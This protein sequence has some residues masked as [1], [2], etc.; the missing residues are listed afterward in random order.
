M[1]VFVAGATGAI[2]QVVAPKAF[3]SRPAGQ[4]NELQILCRGEQVQVTLNGQRITDARMDEHE[5]LKKRPHRGYIGLSA[6]S[7]P[8]RF[9]NVRLHELSATAV[10]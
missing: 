9:R 7:G 8:A 3:A 5:A 1:R 6:H 2:Y 10:K 4:W